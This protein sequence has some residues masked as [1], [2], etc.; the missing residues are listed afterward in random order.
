MAG[1]KKKV[2]SRKSV[3]GKAGSGKTLNM[4]GMAKADEFLRE[5]G[6]DPKIKMVKKAAKKKVASKKGRKKKK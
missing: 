1:K 3:N 2:S 6:A 4:S 5:M